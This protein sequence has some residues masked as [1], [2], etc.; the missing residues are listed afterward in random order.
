MGYAILETTQESGDSKGSYTATLSVL[1]LGLSDEPGNVLNRGLVFIV[2]PEG[3][4]LEA[5]LIDQNSCVCLETGE[6]EHQV[7]VDF[8]YFSNSAGVLQLL[9]SGLLNC[10][11]DAVF[12]LEG[13]GGVTPVDGFKGVLDLEELTVRCENSDCFIVSWHLYDLDIVLL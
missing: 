13:H 12:S 6:G 2:E 10:H 11:D 1:L 4:A 3:L 5:G 7:V 9:I 8:A